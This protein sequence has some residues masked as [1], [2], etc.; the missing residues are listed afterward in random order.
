M[1]YLEE[2]VV[3]LVR[4]NDSIAHYYDHSG[5]RYTFHDDDEFLDYVQDPH[6]DRKSV[7]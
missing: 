5:T 4:S 6:Q 2:F 3:L 1:Q 7:V